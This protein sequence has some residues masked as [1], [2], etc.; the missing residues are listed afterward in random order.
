MECPVCRE[1]MVIIEYESIELDYCVGCMG[2]WFDSGEVEL[3]LEKAGVSV[4][5]DALKLVDASSELRE[6]SRPC[7]LCRKNMRKVSP[8]ETGIILD[9]CPDNEGLWFDAGEVGET[10]K[11]MAGASSNIVIQVLQ[12]FL[13]KAVSSNNE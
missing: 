3:L 5:S 9:Q 2:I 10:V 11:Q 1:S 12:D 7:P 6:L 4:P 8:P 13:G